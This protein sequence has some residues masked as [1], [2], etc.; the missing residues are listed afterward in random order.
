MKYI[1]TLCVV[2]TILFSFGCQSSQQTVQSSSGIDRQSKLLAAE[3][4]SIKEELD[5]TRRELAKQTKLFEQ[6]KLDNQKTKEQAALNEKQIESLKQTIN[7]SNQIITDLRKQLAECQNMVEE[8]GE[9]ALC[10]H[11][12]QQ[13]KKMLAECEKA[14]QEIESSVSANADFLMSKIPDDLMKQVNVLTAENQQL[15]E[16]IAELEKQLKHSKPKTQN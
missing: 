5:K 8:K 12:L 3:N 13:Q 16:K 10:R 15:T 2:G 9:P 7:S 14:K 4:I 1:S 11:K 6:I